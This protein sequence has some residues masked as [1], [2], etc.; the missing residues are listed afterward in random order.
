MPVQRKLQEFLENLYSVFVLLSALP[1]PTWT[2]MYLNYLL[3]FS[4]SIPPFNLW[5]ASEP[6]L[7]GFNAQILDTDPE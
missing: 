3:Q 2:A 5:P 7:L 1:G 6:L 4:V